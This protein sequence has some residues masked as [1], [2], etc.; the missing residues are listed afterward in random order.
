VGSRVRVL[1]ERQAAKTAAAGAAADQ[2][3]RSGEMQVAAQHGAEPGP[4]KSAAPS[5]SAA[6]QKSAIPQKSAAPPKRQ[7]DDDGS[8]AAPGVVPIGSL[9]EP[10]RAVVE[11]RVRVVEIRP[12]ERNSVLAAEISDSTGELTALFYGRSHIPGI[13]CGA[14]VRFR[15]SVG[16]KNGHPVMTNPAYELLFPGV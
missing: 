3:L 5:K 16:I 8:P 7:Q 10:G 9:T 12:V 15:G 6:P 14:R 2:Q 4:P 11:G 13:V 1:S